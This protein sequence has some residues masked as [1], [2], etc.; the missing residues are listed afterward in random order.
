M[1]M[2]SAN[3]KIVLFPPSQSIYLSFP[4]SV[5]SHY[6]G[7]PAQYWGKKMVQKVTS[8]LCF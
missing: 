4:L 2:L 8:L 5:L 6:L 1:I 3:K 7:L